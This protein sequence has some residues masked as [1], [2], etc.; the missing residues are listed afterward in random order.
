[1]G[2]LAIY[3]VGCL[4]LMTMAS[5]EN[6]PSFRVEGTVSGA[7]GRMLYLEQVGIEDIE[8]L[9]SIK[10]NAK[11]VFDFSEN[12]PQT[13]E[14]YRLR[15]A[16]KIINFAIDSTEIIK[17][18]AQY[19]DFPTGYSIS[20]SENND[21]IK[22]LV[23]RQIN[24]QDQVGKLF[25]L[26]EKGQIDG[27]SLQNNL[28]ELLK[29]Y[30]DTVKI[31][32]IFALF[33]KVGDYLIF[34]PLNSKDDIKCFGAVATSIN[35]LYPHADRSKN[36]YNIVIKGMKNTRKSQQKNVELPEGTISESGII[37]IDLKDVKGKSHKLSDLKGKV[38]LLDFS[39]YQSPAASPHNI[40]LNELYKKYA[41]QGLEIYQISLDAD[42]HFWKTMADKLPWICVRDPEGIY[43]AVT[44]TYNIRKVPSYFLINKNNELSKRDENIKNLEEEIKKML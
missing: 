34:D 21:K 30:K 17:I 16:D 3:T 10:L 25:E 20:G 15:I 38:V 37:D 6:K 14:F 29:S 12:R 11:G 7:E 23:L 28:S 44:Q 2:K 26:S 36:L 9:D 8:T 19:N 43:S 27:N 41:S 24:L 42:E 40:A 5:C 33:Q 31:N 35:N 1:M 13:P 22:E 32:Y 39:V 18:K 4:L